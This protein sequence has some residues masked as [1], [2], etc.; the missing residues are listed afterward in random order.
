M[1]PV[2]RAIL[3]FL[4]REPRPI[5]DLLAQYPKATLYRRLRALRSRGLIAK[6]GARYALTSAGE[7]A[8]ASA[9][10][11]AFANSLGA[12]YPP[13]G[14]IPT[15]QHRAMVELSLAALVLRQHTD[16]EDRH[17]G[18]L[19]LGP[20][21]TWK[22]SAGVFVCLMAGV[23]P[24]THV[25]D[26]ATEAGKSL[27][28]R[29]GAAGEI[30]AQRELLDAPTVVFDE[31]HRAEP[32]V[33]RAIAPFLGGRRQVPFENEV[34]AIRPVPILTMNP[35]PAA[36]LSARTGLSVPQLRRLVPCD[37][38]AVQLPDLA[39]HGQ[40][41]LEVARQDGPLPLRPP[42]GSCERFRPSVV[43]LFRRAIRSEAVG[44][45][46]VDLVLGLARGFTAWLPELEAL[47]L[48]LYDVLLAVETVGWAKPG[49]VDSVRA[50]PD[51]AADQTD[52]DG[53][54]SGPHA[55]P[56][57]EPAAQRITLFPERSQPGALP[58][59]RS[60]SPRES[61]LPAL[62]LSEE[63]KRRLVW[64]SEE[65]RLP[66]DGTVRILIRVYELWRKRDATFG[67]LHAIVRLREQCEAAE[68][69]VDDLRWT[70]EQLVK[71]ETHDLEIEDVAEAVQLAQDLSQAGL[72]TGQAREV[73][74]LLAAL[75]EA[76][77]DRGVPAEL[78][79]TL[80]RYRQLGYSPETLTRLSA[81]AETLE[82]LGLQPGELGAA[83]EHL[84]R[85]RVLGLDPDAA[86]QVAQNLD[87]AGFQGEHRAEVLARLPEAAAALVDIDQLRTQRRA[88]EDVLGRLEGACTQAK[89]TLSTLRARQA[90]ALERERTR[91]AELEAL[92][93]A[94]ARQEAALAALT[95]E[96]QKQQVTL[97]ALEAFARFMMGQ[98]ADDPLWPLMGALWELKRTPADQHP[99]LE[100]FLTRHVR[101]M[102]REFLEKISPAP[103][104][105]GDGS[106]P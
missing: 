61:L 60:G 93:Q 50:F 65:V 35:G 44:L 87:A 84:Q 78:Q 11:P 67:Q 34:V 31:Y 62:S 89:K 101:Q 6:H 29:R 27:W 3:S 70:L 14:E 43:R 63:T 15:P 96:C 58:E 16:Q 71:L 99:E 86:E 98:P 72:T 83:L 30:V 41:A 47:R 40:R 28:I 66:L 94:C 18:F 23:D 5:R 80:E 19:F 13:L 36:T 42:Q 45:L 53:G 17:A 104:A 46:D 2:D 8:K 88:L 85:L 26:C 22:T 48:T 82:T 12:V 90:T 32:P 100:A 51:M 68:F 38:G 103:K 56:L 97:A 25:V 69:A 57:P 39:L 1:T 4:T 76:G 102:I 73:A 20:T 54:G 64:L 52:Q 77:I 9:E 106:A 92:R 7:Q 79:A 33:R 105:L 55:V 91:A 10:G 95:R 74:D 37:V 24:V 59:S 49:W 21:L 81:L 75:E